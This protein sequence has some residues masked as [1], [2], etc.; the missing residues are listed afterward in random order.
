MFH[1]R[2]DLE[3]GDDR[4]HGDERDGEVQQTEHDFLKGEQHLVDADLL[5][6]RSRI[7]DGAHGARCGI[8]HEREQGLAE[9]QVDGEVW[10]VEPEHHGEHCGE[11]DHH[12]QGIQHRPQHA[13]HASS[14][15]ELEIL[16]NER[17]EDEPIPFELCLSCT[18]IADRCLSDAT[19]PCAVCSAIFAKP[20]DTTDRLFSFSGKV[21]SILYA[22]YATLA[23]VVRQIPYFR[24]L[25]AGWQ[26]SSHVG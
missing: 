3:E 16:R 13:E 7:D 14:I 2:G 24:R 18:H 4:R 25:A 5:D 8:A 11:H 21:E 10:D 9:D 12:E 23:D 17:G 1:V 19:R 26:G 22:L 6:E 15:F 20:H